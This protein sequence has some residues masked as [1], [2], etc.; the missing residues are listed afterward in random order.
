MSRAPAHSAIAWPSPVPSQEF[1]VNFQDLP[2]PP[3][4]KMT[5]LAWKVTNSPVAR[6]YP[7][8]PAMR[9][10]PSWRSFKTFNSMKTSV[11][12][13]TTFCCN[14]RISSNPVRSPTWASRA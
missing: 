11:P 6:Q 10:S 9:P 5:V 14:V 3:V 7:T 12:M 4:A 2:A 8:Q 1:E 13:E